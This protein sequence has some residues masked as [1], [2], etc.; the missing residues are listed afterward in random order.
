VYSLGVAPSAP[1]LSIVGGAQAC[2]V[3]IRLP[4]G[5][6]FDRVAVVL[7]TYFQRGPALRVQ[8]LDDRTEKVLGKGQ[9]P[10]GYPDI[11][12][13]PEHVIDVGR[14]ETT[15]PLRICIVNDGENK[16]AVYGQPTI[17]SPYTNATL[18]GQ[19]SS[20]DIWLE[21]RAEKRTLM[22][23]LP[24]MAE[25]ASLFRAGWVTPLVY[26]LLALAL[27][28]GAPLLLARAVG[29]AAAADAE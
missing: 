21:L 5:A 23:L 26:L 27:V 8:V 7:G 15:A 25:R 2:Q 14:V 12:Q 17:A 19:L 10:A 3:P 16:V 29:W 24:T 13:A 22:S 4:D 1:V 18:N 11:A 9:L 6:A 20:V 28:I